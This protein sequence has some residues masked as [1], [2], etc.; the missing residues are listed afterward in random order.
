[1]A[2]TFGNS[3]EVLTRKKH[4]RPCQSALQSQSA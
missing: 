2:R 4:F 1:M 3:A